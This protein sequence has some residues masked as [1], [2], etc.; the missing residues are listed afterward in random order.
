[1]GYMKNL[2]IKKND[3]IVFSE[4]TDAY[5]K[6]LGFYDGTTLRPTHAAVLETDKDFALGTPCLAYDV[7]LTL[8]LSVNV[9]MTPREIYLELNKSYG[10][11]ISHKHIVFPEPLTSIYDLEKQLDIITSSIPRSD[12]DNIVGSVH[13]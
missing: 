11:F 8:W 12:L 9:Q 3:S 4:E 1:M 5:F 6:S 13:V 2:R 7:E 10:D